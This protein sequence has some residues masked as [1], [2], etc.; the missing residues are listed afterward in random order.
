MKL[1]Y[2]LI[3][4]TLSTACAAVDLNMT[5]LLSDSSWTTQNGPA[6]ATNANSNGEYFTEFQVPLLSDLSISGQWARL[7]DS[8]NDGYD[9]SRILRPVEWSIAA[10]SRTSIARELGINW[11]VFEGL[12]AHAKVQT[13]NG[14]AW[15]PQVSIPRFVTQDSEHW[16]L[17][18]VELVY[19]F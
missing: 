19:T 11:T 7:H 9:A 12:Q 2:L 6:L 4:L 3:L 10:E 5:K 1:A 15:I 17:A 8:Y 16:T 18:A 14:S 13:V